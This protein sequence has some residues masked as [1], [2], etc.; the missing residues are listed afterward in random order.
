MAGDILTSDEA[1]ADL[2]EVSL[3]Y[4]TF[5]D[6]TDEPLL[7]VMGLGGPMIWWD[8]A[9]CVELAR[10][11]FHVIRY[12]NRDTG[13]STRIEHR[14]DRATLVKAFLGLPIQAPY[15][16]G[17]LARDAVGLLNHLSI[18]SAHVAGVSMGGMISQALT[19]EHPDRVRTLT[20]IM[21]TTGRRTV[22]WQHPSLLPG[23]LARRSGD[24]ELYVASAADYWAMIGSPAY[25]STPERRRQRAADTWD[26]GISFSGVVRHM[27][28]VVSQEDRTAALADVTCPVTVLHGTAD[29]LVHISGGRATARAVPGAELVEMKGMGHDLPPALFGVFSDII[30]NNADRA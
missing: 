19:I 5:G 13:R 2:G 3:C 1:F 28:A 6:P 25:P 8:D 20:S 23:L 27:V 7:L 15:G 21:S 29:K 22:G 9:L 10:R 14:V 11:G 30:R 12:D 16:I 26:R 17:D 24:R 4:Q 18:D